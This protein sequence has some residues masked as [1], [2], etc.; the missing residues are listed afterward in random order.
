M[1]PDHKKRRVEE[2]SHTQGP[3]DEQ[4]GQRRAFPIDVPSDE[5][6]DMSV[7]LYLRSVREEAENDRVFYATKTPIDT[8]D[9]AIPEVES[10]QNQSP[11][12]LVQQED[13]DQITKTLILE[14]DKLPNQATD[15]NTFIPVSSLIAD[16]GSEEDMGRES[17]A[18]DLDP[19]QHD[20]NSESNRQSS[21]ETPSVPQ[22]AGQWRELVFT[23]APSTDFLL[24]LEHTTV[25][26]LIIYYT[27]WLLTL[28]PE[29]LSKWIFATFVRLDK[30][31]NFA[32]VSIVRDLGKKA[33][34]LLTK[35]HD[36]DAL[37]ST[38]KYTLAMVLAVVGAYYG[39]KDLLYG[40]DG[41]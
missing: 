11:Q 29:K 32:E 5:H 20:G 33:R 22:S 37:S 4:F 41:V 12:L 38:V 18:E 40:E 2:K 35:A 17:E 25:V 9:D 26:K 19:N 30:G 15:N 8:T 16:T 1:A 23:T 10:H 27:K 28:M 3:L 14:K 34:K 13:I 24:L 21:T 36:D 31:L 39:Q 6:D 7:F